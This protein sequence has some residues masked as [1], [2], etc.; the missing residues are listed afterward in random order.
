M[1]KI[2]EIIRVQKKH[3]HALDEQEIESLLTI[4]ETKFQTA[5]SVSIRLLQ[6][7]P[8]LESYPEG[9]QVQ[10]LEHALDG[11]PFQVKKDTM[12]PSSNPIQ[13]YQFTLTAAPEKTRFHELWMKNSVLELTKV[14]RQTEKIL[15]EM[16]EMW[17]D[18][19]T[20]VI[21]YHLTK[22]TAKRL[23]ELDEKHLLAMKELEGGKYEF[24]LNFL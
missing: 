9:I 19:P 10:L 7:I 24:R 11:F 13:A 12:V 2:S 14:D 23:M 4:L 18:C 1:D 21:G 3:F 5:E 15:S 22:E 6:P 8:R 16:A 17:E 20:M